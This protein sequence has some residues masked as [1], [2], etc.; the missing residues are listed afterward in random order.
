MGV[1]SM[2]GRRV[3]G[4]PSC[5]QGYVGEVRF[6]SET[7]WCS[8]QSGSVDKIKKN[9]HFVKTTVSAEESCLVLSLPLSLNEYDV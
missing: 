6:E 8:L 1:S 9:Q 5:I 4:T 2:E 3:W 7:C